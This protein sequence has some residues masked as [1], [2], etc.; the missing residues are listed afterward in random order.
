MT[1]SLLDYWKLALFN[2]CSNTA[3]FQPGQLDVHG[4]SADSH[5]EADVMGLVM[6]L[7]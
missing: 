5:R 2:S 6:R 3:H 4:R 7:S 1:V